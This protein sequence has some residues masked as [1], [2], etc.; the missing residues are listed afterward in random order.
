MGNPIAKRWCIFIKGCLASPMRVGSGQKEQTDYDVLCDADGRPFVPGSSLAGA[1]RHYME[2]IFA[3]E[4]ERE[5]IQGLFGPRLRDVGL[6]SRLICH[7]MTFGE[8]AV[9]SKRD[10]VRLDE[11]KTAVQ[12]AKYDMQFVERGTPFKLRLEWVIRS[13]K[14]DTEAEATEEA[15]LCTLIDGLTQGKLTVGAKGR[16][17]FGELAVTGVGVRKFDHRN[18]EEIRQWLDW[19]WNGMEEICESWQSGISGLISEYRTVDLTERRTCEE[20]ELCVPLKIKHTIMIRHYATDPES[21]GLDADYVQL[22]DGKAY[23]VIPGTSWAGAIR[24]HLAALLEELGVEE[25]DAKKKLNELFGQLSKQRDANRSEASESALTASRLRFA[26]SVI[27]GGTDLPTTRTAVDRFTGGARTGALYTSR[28]WVDGT[29]KL[30]VRWRY[31][32]GKDDDISPDVICG[33]MIWVIR[34][35]EDGLLAVGGETAIGRGM[36]DTVGDIELNGKPLENDEQCCRKA[37][38]WCLKPLQKDAGEV[39]AP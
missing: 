24:H 3:G 36:L 12:E 8:D 18:K 11:Y 19:N 32:R 23:P 15:L 25:E 7:H 13:D 16:R 34:D 26:E 10:G 35:L 4:E 33:V 2:E 27:E 29:T 5:A 39:C 30:R 6:K 21:E 38:E 1:F 31:Q 20:Y 22:K 37:L 28:P 14:A 9:L 17:G